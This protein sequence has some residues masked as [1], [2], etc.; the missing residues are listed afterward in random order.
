LSLNHGR[1][2]GE[3][4]AARTRAKPAESAAWRGRSAGRRGREQTGA[5][6]AVQGA[7]GSRRRPSPE[8]RGNL[9]IGK[10]PSAGSTNRRHRDEAPDKTNTTVPSDSADDV[11]IE[12][13]C[14][15]ELL[16]KLEPS[17]TSASNSGSFRSNLRVGFR[18]LEMV[19]RE[20]SSHKYIARVLRYFIF[21]NYPI[22]KIK[23]LF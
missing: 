13:N 16:A 10:E 3:E 21:H 19:R 18:I 5:A 1:G 6:T 22:F 9:L 12:S 14:S 23:N 8:L 2:R 7:R 15:P 4:G 17:R 11:Q 20:D